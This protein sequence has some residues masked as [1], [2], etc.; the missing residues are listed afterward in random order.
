MHWETVTPRFQVSRKEAGR[1]I[2][3]YGS[4]G[5]WHLSHSSPWVWNDITFIFM[6][7]L[8]WLEA[9]FY[10]FLCHSK[11]RKKKSFLRNYPG[12]IFLKWSFEPSVGVCEYTT[13]IHKQVLSSAIPVAPAMFL[14]F[15]RAVPSWG[16]LDGSRKNVSVCFNVWAKIS[17]FPNPPENF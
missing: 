15:A 16:L 2:W 7:T 5:N 11:K 14:L 4:C 3:P 12:R 6:S 9:L 13:W 10:I 17:V 1:G 8:Q